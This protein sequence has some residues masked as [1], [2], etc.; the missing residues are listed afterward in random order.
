MGA[1]PELA[2]ARSLLEYIFFFYEN[3][4]LEREI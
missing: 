3:E 4:G 2:A 1:A